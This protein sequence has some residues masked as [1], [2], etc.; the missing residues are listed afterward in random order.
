MKRKAFVAA[1]NRA[2]NVYLNYPESNV[3]EAL[4]I[5]YISYKELQIKDL[6]LATKKII[7]LNYPN[8][9]ISSKNSEETRKWW[10]FWDSMID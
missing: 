8:L 10:K 5:Q 9:D 1:L 6:E 3:K 4:I 7:D 2:K